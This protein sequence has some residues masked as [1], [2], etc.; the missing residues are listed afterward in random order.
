MYDAM[1]IGDEDL[2][3]AR[4]GRID[5]LDCFAGLDPPSSIVQIEEGP[6]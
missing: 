6:L 5:V 3:V 2:F 1:H 4:H